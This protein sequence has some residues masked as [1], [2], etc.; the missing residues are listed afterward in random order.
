MLEPCGYT[1]PKDI[2]DTTVIQQ[3]KQHFQKIQEI[4]SETTSQTYFDTF[5]WRLYQADRVLIH[6]GKRQ[7]TW[8]ELNKP[9]VIRKVPSRKVPKFIWEWN[10]T[11]ALPELPDIIEMRALL[12]QMKMQTNETLYRFF[13]KEDKTILRLVLVNYTLEQGSKSLPVSQLLLFPLRG[14]NKIF[15][16]M[17]EFLLSGLQLQKTS[18]SILLKALELNDITP[19]TYTSKPKIHLFNNMT[20]ETALRK[21]LLQMVQSI[22]VNE[23]GTAEDIDSEFLHDFRVS[24]RRTR[25]AQGQIKNVLPAN[26]LEPARKDFAWIG[27]ITGPTRDMDVYLLK[28]DEYKN[29]VPEGMRDDLKPL[30]DFLIRR[31]RAEQKKLAKHIAGERYQSIMSNWQTFLETPLEKNDSP[32]AKRPVKDVADE[33]IGSI[34]SRIIKHGARIST[35]TP[36][37]ALHDLR[38]ECKKLRYLMEFF[39]SL[40]DAAKIKDL[41]QILKQL[42]SNLG[43]FQDF[44]VQIDK[45]KEFSQEMLESGKTPANTIMAM[46]ILV[47][48]LI[49]KQQG[50]RDEFAQQFANFASSK[51]LFQHLFP[52]RTIAHEQ[53]Q[54]TPPQ[55]VLS[56]PV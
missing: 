38:K 21:I 46:G 35:T 20:T 13:D 39:L 40:Y 7:V 36:A 26:I 41:M 32:N 6:D 52:Q 5:D 30:K 24:V 50:A 22:R 9:V 56:T 15:N 29:S 37:E 12:P 2:S 17:N 34:Y 51:E 10:E 53:N 23:K 42:Q 14:Y 27:Q 8:G 3:L 11:I 19:A 48:R 16:R 4:S 1:L 18:K 45:L 44:E 31:Q 28:I 43:D 25:S 55:T 49:E 54:K 33:R 47:E